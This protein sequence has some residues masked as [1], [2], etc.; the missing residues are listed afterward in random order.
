MM[1][2]SPLSKDTEMFFGPRGFRHVTLCL[3]S[4]NRENFGGGWGMVDGG[5][6]GF[7][8]GPLLGLILLRGA[9]LMLVTSLKWARPVQS[10]DMIMKS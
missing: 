6:G 2:R 5:G 1:R 4:D 7:M 3:K 9:V 10:R 8:G